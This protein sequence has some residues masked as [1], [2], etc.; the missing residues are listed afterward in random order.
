MNAPHVPGDADK[1]AFLHIRDLLEDVG[2]LDVKQIA[3]ELDFPP[4]HVRRVVENA[5]HGGQLE[6]VGDRYK[7]PLGGAR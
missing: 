6:Q 5:C 4:D 7:L 3:D 2:T 1:L